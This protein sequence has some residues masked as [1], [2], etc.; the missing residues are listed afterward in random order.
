MLFWWIIIFCVIELY[1]VSIAVFTK[2]RG[3]DG[4]VHNLIPFVAFTYPNRNTAGFKIMSIPVK[5]FLGV[6][7]WLV[8]ILAFC[9]LWLWWGQYNLFESDYKSLDMIL[10]IPTVICIIVF[11]LGL[12][13]ST[14]ALAL[15]YNFTFKCETLVYMLGISVP[16]VLMAAPVRT[17]RALRQ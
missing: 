7:L 16:I 17:P 13:G 9:S 3:E 1:G 15:R 6:V 12:I 4:W 10:K 11:W 5:N 2:R 8:V 14:K